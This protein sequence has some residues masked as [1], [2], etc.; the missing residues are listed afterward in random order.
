M[1]VLV[2]AANAAEVERLTEENA[3]LRQEVEKLKQE[4]S[5]AE[6]RHGGLSSAVN[7][8]CGYLASVLMG[9]NRHFACPFVS[10]VLAPVICH[11][12]CLCVHPIWC[13]SSKT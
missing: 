2:S 5:A 11:S 9:C 7:Y 1:H 12:V 3:L 13:T 4:L 6:M 8:F 10:P